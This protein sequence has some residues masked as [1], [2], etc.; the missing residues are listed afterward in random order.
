M[1]IK[2]NIQSGE[3]EFVTYLGGDGYSAPVAYKKTFDNA[4]NAQEQML[5]LH[6]DYQGS[7]IA[8]TNDTGAIVE[9]RQFDAWGAIM[10]VQDGNNNV[11]N[12]LTILDRGYTGHEHLQSV[13]LINMNGRLYD[14]K[15][16]RFLQPDNYVQDA[17]NTQNYNRYSYVLNNP[18]KYT[19]PSGEKWKITWSDVVSAFSIVAGTV[20]TFTGF[21]MIGVPLIGAGVAHFTTAIN[22]FK[23]TGDWVS[24][25]NNAG[26]IVSFTVKTDFG[27]DSDNK[28]NGITQT[29]PVVKP[30]AA[31]DV[32]NMS[33]GGSGFVNGFSD[34]FGAGIDSTIG[35]FKSLGTVEG[36][37]AVGDGFYT[38]GMAACLF[39]PE[40]SDT[41]SQMVNAPI[42][43]FENVPNMSAYAI[44]YDIGY[45]TEKGFEIAITRRVMPLPKSFLG[46][47][48]VG[49]ASRFTTIQ[50]IRTYK[51]WGTL[52]KRSFTWPTGGYTIDR[53]TFYNRNYIIPAGRVIGAGQLQYLQKK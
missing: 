8:I 46:V 52:S 41:R 3:I 11:L 2:Q 37:Q 44:G 21:P 10:Q 13:G 31:D 28:P 39:C 40:G 1:E 4:G 24:A 42:N 51:G 19:D 26:F 30:I 38:I 43:Y 14:P 48:D 29:E 15:L 16:H 18:L 12:G 47:R 7:I 34:G 6:R 50:S 5:Y 20:L 22:E 25:S 45:G 9:K 35:F 17:S 33:S 53:A 32:R 36:W 49:E 27:Y 23:Q